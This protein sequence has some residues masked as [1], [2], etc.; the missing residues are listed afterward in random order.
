MARED[1][2]IMEKFVA[3]GTGELAGRDLQRANAPQ[4]GNALTE[5]QI[6]RSREDKSRQQQSLI[7]QFANQPKPQRV[8]GGGGV[9]NPNAPTALI[10]AVDPGKQFAGTSDKFMLNYDKEGAEQSLSFGDF[11]TLVDKIKE[12]KAKGVNIQLPGI[13]EGFDQASF[14]ALQD[15]GVVNTT[16]RDSLISAFGRANR[17]DNIFGPRALS[18]SKQGETRSNPNTALLKEL[19]AIMAASGKG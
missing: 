15:L 5:S 16:E 4:L 13:Q 2:R 6:I 11:N 8:Q 12:L 14:K 7:K 1:E 18:N 19:Q 9:S 17:Q 10:R 3:R